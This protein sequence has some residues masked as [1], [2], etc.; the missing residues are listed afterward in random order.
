MSYFIKQKVEKLQKRLKQTFS[1]FQDQSVG[2]NSAALGG[3]LRARYA[4]KSRAA[5]NGDNGVVNGDESET[6]NESPAS[7]NEISSRAAKYKLAASPNKDA[8]EVSF[9]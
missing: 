8:G 3:A 9:P 5:T 4:A 6:G 2:A 7:F 1:R